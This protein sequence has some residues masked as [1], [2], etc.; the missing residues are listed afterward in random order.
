MDGS[1]TDPEPAT[2]VA[3]EIVAT[4][5]L[6]VADTN[7]LAGA[8]GAEALVAGAVDRFGRVDIVINNAGIIE[9]AGF[10]EADEDN[11]M[12]HLSVHTIGAFGTAR[13]AWPHMAAR[14]YGR[15]VMTTSSGIL[16]LPTNA[17]Y[18]TAK[19]AVIGLTRSLAVAGAPH[20]IA[21][22]LI[23]PAAT[24]RMAGGRGPAA[25]TPEQVAPMAAYLAH[26][27]C[28]VSGE[29]YAAGAGRFARLFL[30]STTGYVAPQPVPSME[31]V[32]SHWDEINDESGYWVPA[33][34]M[35]WSATFL[36][37]VG[38]ADAGDEGD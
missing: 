27:A 33:D 23:A 8:A 32:A 1:G 36:D 22:N 13:A 7:D 17:S 21:V 12:R 30:A 24:T 2:A 4:G 20:G 18:A 25:M 16:G 14:G 29:I 37:H 10:P 26:E 19:A 35:Q 11:L 6:A 9:W 3:A 5:G 31:D 38:Q 15:I 34:L 28:P